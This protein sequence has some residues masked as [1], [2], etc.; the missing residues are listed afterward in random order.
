MYNL[1]N[2][3]MAFTSTSGEIIS[4]YNSKLSI[5]SANSAFKASYI[6]VSY[7]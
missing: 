7:I 3:C 1:I 5:S 2:L 6:S 4:E